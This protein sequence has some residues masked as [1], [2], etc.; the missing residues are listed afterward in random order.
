MIWLVWFGC[1]FETVV[2]LY[3][4][5]L[6]A[7]V[8]CLV[9]CWWYCDWVWLLLYGLRVCLCCLTLVDLFEVDDGYLWWFP[10]WS[11]LVFGVVALVCVIL[12]VFDCLFEFWLLG[13]EVFCFDLCW[14]I[15]SLFSIW[16]V[17]W[18]LLCGFGVC[19]LIVGFCLDDFVLFLVCWVFIRMWIRWCLLAGVCWFGVVC[20]CIWW[21]RCLFSL[22][23]LLDF[24]ILVGSL[25]VALVGCFSYLLIVRII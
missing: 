15:A 19:F 16:L 5:C 10:Y 17:F 2:F 3:W 22:S 25:L 20:F 18:S 14:V 9:E 24:V 4:L 1:L 12:F 13:F 21:L 8:D 6:F 11:L 7:I 23:C